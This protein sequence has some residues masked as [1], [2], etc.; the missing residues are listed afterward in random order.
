MAFLAARNS[1]RGGLGE[2][3]GLDCELVDNIFSQYAQTE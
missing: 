3:T 2:E 1:E